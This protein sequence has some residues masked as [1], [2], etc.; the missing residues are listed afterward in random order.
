MIVIQHSVESLNST[1]KTKS[2]PIVTI[3]LINSVPVK[4]LIDS[5]ESRV[6]GTGLV[7]AVGFVVVITDAAGVSDDPV[8]RKPGHLLMNNFFLSNIL[9]F[10]NTIC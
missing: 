5:G 4:T 8:S 2:P 10:S 9:A 3:V 1:P 7:T 6:H